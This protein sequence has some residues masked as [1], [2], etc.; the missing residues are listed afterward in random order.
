MPDKLQNTSSVTTNS[1]RKAGLVTDLNDSLVNEEQY[2]HARNAVRNSKD[3]DLGAIG[4]EPSNTLCFQAPY[5]IVGSINITDDDVVI[6]S[7]NNVKSEIG[8]GNSVTCA[9]SKLYADDCLAFNDAFPVIGESK[10]DFQKGTII[11]FTDKNNPPR[12]L[13]L[14]NVSKVD[15]CDDLRVFRKIKYPCIDLQKGQ[16]GNMPNG[17]YSVALAYVVNGQVF[18]DWYGLSQ[19]QPLFSLTN[20]N[21]MDIKLSNID[22][23]F[24]HFA[25][26]VI[27]NYVDPSTKGVTKVAKQIGIYS[28][29]TRSISLTDFI[30][31]T[32]KELELSTF[33]IQ[34]PTWT[35]AGIISSNANYLLFA[36]LVARPEED[37]QLKALDIETEYVVEQVL[38]DYYETD[39]Q[40]VGYYR[41]ENYDFYIQGVYNTGELTDKFYIPGRVSTGDDMAPVSSPDVYELDKQF[42]DCETKDAIPRWRVENTAGKLIPEQNDFKCDR[43]V[44]GTGEMGYFEST[45]LLPDNKATFGRYANKPIRYHKMPDECKVPRYTKIG[46]K[47]YINILGVRFK[48]IPK[49]DNPDIVGYKITRSDRK[50][51]NGTV[52]ARGL[53][54]NVRSYHDRSFDETVYYSNYPVNDLSPDQFLSSTQTVFKNHK[55]TNFTPLEDYSKDRFTFYSPHTSFEPKYSLGPEIKIECEEV[56]DVTGKFDI[57]YQHPQA[58]LLTQ[59]AFWVA[60]TIGTIETYF[61]AQGLKTRTTT[62]GSGNFAGKASLSFTGTLAGAAGGAITTTPGPQSSIGFGTGTQGKGVTEATNSTSQGGGSALSI[63]GTATQDAIT[64]LL[65]IIASNPT[66]PTNWKQVKTYIKI[67]KDVLKII[68]AAAATAALAV[69]SIIRYA[70]E[71]L[72]TIYNFMGFTDYVY[73]YNASAIFNSS[74]CVTEGNKRRRLLKPALFIPSTVVNIEGDIYN[75]LFREETIYLQLNKEIGDPKTKDTTR[76]TASGFKLCDDISQKAKSVGSAFYVTNKEIN[77]N[78]YGQ[79]GSS[80][81]VSMHGCMLEF[82]GDLTTT[83]ILYGGDCIISRFQFQKRMKFF[84]QDLAGSNFRPETEYDYRKYRNLAYP[85]F[86]M[87]TTKFDFSELLTNKTINYAK[88]NRTTASKYNLDCIGDDKKNISRVDDAYMY[89]SNNAG[90]DFFVEADYNVAFREKQ[91]N[92]MPYYSKTNRDVHDIFR[93]DRLGTPEEFVISRAYSDLYP[94]EIYAPIQRYDFDPLD[95]IPTSQPNAVIYSLPAFNLQQVDNWQHFL[96]A[97]YFDFRESDFG[98]LTGIHKMDQDRIIF[99]FSKASPFVTMGKDFL[100][101][102]QSGRKVTIGDGGLFAQDPRESMPTD[103]NYGACNSKYAFSN[104]HLGRFYPSERQGRFFDFT[105]TPVD[106]SANGMSFW[107]KNYMPIMLY[108]YFPSYPQIEN[109]I[110]G[111]GYL[112][113]FDSFNETVYVTKR[114]FSPK[115]DLIKDILWD[116]V[117]S[118]FKYKGNPIELRDGRYF[119]DISWTLSYAPGDKAFVSWHDWHPDW[120]I[121]TDTHFLTVKGNGVWKHNDNYESFCNFYN[122]DYPFEIEFLSNSGQQID[123]PRSLEYMLEVYHYKNFG[124]DRFHVHHENFSHLIVYNTEQMSPLLALNYSTSNPEQN[125][126]FPKKSTLN[127][128]TFDILFSKEENKYRVNQFWSSVK[129]RGEFS[130]AENHLFPTD[131]SGYRQVINPQAIDMNKPEEQR[132]KFRHYF[133]KFRLIRSVSGKNKFICKLFN[134]KKV[135]SIR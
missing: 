31:T 12:R 28:T 50:G 84:T 135:V 43:R 89:L 73:Q 5:K 48:N 133:N 96:P 118:T 88:F 91:S 71:V 113:V 45:E 72:N 61:E 82:D 124:R 87:D 128:I 116:N 36:D 76:N 60:L 7:T 129:D 47:T 62:S 22:T 126:L 83:P 53:M 34:K 117:S 57:V 93:S 64:D 2:T 97:N 95:R 125:I 119:N 134:I 33:V 21:S 20:S 11:Y 35:K 15:D 16:S 115:R 69:M 131:E 44:L 99:M 51:G 37:Y 30:N 122:V 27:G 130:L 107:C 123:I 77:P 3:G 4:N 10:K 9:Y 39:G 6:F 92:D 67:L 18:S 55:E 52:I 98:A 111:V 74:T 1:I 121:Q 127:N 63:T 8:I 81:S 106:V 42:S 56:A 109:P 80:S 85:R 23:E 66:N 17:M 132:A 101:L 40:D 75:N 24:D 102:E 13:E 120:V 25:L 14:K 32:Y 54:T 86:W 41:D 114:D 112:T 105:G 59:F 100:E 90:L 38:A 19:R 46:D 70:D 78:Q 49:F 65:A 94:V 58:K 26:A 103:N 104:T 108:K 29:K 68:A 110:S 79:L